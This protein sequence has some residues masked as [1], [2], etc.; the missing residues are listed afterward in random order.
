MQLD[1]PLGEGRKVCT[2]CKIEKPLS[3][4]NA[5]NTGKDKRRSKCR[6]CTTAAKRV[7]ENTPEG[8]YITYKR[9]A[10]IRNYIFDITQE[11]FTRLVSLPCAYCGKV[12]EPEVNLNGLDRVYNDL[13]YTLDNVVPCC[14]V[15]NFSK[16]QLDFDQFIEHTRKVQEYSKQKRKTPSVSYQKSNVE[17]MKVYLLDSE[18]GEIK[19][20]DFSFPIW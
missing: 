5:D 20:E 9:G 18:V 2:T 16:G 10:R 13:P 12:S 7:Y 14:S 19:Q 8:M 1:L 15:C 6:V 3:E 4:F 11:E 17:W